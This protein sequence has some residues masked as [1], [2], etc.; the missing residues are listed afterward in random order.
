MP[1]NL[2]SIEFLS[3]GEKKNLSRELLKAFYMLPIFVL[4]V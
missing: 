4:V 3:L 1:I 2:D